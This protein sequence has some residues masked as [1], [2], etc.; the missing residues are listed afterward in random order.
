MGAILFPAIFNVCIVVALKL[1]KK[2]YDIDLACSA[3]GHTIAG[4]VV[5]FLLVAR[6]NS[7]LARYNESR[8]FIGIMYRET[9][10]I[11]Q[12][13]LV[14]SR[15]KKNSTQSDKEW[16]SELAYRTM[17]LLQTT[18]AT[19]QYPTHRVPAYEIPSLSGVE[20]QCATPDRSFLQRA[21]IPFS[22]EANS[23]RV[24][25]R[26]AQLVRETVC[27]QNERLSHPISIQQEM[28]LLASVDKYQGGYYGMR[29]FMVC[30]YSISA[31]SLLL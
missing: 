28:N 27:S 1:L 14:Y 3:L 8:G 18:V 15:S 12:K 13:A 19:T 16:R 21:N 22:E 25:K 5:S 20:L 10:E 7:G 11:V 17:L 9:R 6:I 29:K 24:P 30:A 31:V 23:V 4:L 26:M 2:N